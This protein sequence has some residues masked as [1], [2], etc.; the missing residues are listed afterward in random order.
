MT[1]AT[2]LDEVLYLRSENERLRERCEAYK[3]QVEAGAV[4]ID[5]LRALLQE[6]LG[7]IPDGGSQVIDFAMR[8][9]D[10]LGHT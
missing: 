4:E 6:S 10:K 8:V 3:G 2:T 1:F 9:S 7:I 5:Q